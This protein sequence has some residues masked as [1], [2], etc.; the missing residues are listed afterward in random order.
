[1]F[2]VK[3]AS[4]LLVVALLVGVVSVERGVDDHTGRA[5][6]KFSIS[7]HGIERARLLLLDLADTLQSLR[8]RGG[9]SNP[10]L[11]SAPAEPRLPR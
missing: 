3:I 11:A 8:E 6:V 7:D 1:M 2:P 10:P 9:P 5:W 4:F